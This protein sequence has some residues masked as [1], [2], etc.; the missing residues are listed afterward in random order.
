MYTLDAKMRED[1][2]PPFF[3]AGKKLTERGMDQVEF[4]FS[5][6]P[7]EPVKPLAKI[8]SGGELSR[9]MLALKALVLTPGVVSTLLFDEVDT[10]IGGRVAEIVGKKLKQV[11]RLNQVISV[12]HLPQIAAMADSHY[13]VRKEVAKGRTFTHVERLSEAGKNFRGSAYV[14]RSKDYRKNPASRRRNDRGEIEDQ[15]IKARGKSHLRVLEKVVNGSVKIY[16]GIK[17]KLN[18]RFRIRIIL[19]GLFA[20]KT[21]KKQENC[22]KAA[23]TNQHREMKILIP[24]QNKKEVSTTSFYYRN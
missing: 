10:G 3:V 4:H 8:A 12:T 2:D 24:G 16:D 5:P 6:N 13:V 21:S 18:L 1:D 22:K 11:A 7:G 9:L 23:A 15:I 19:L 20:G 17:V 14:G